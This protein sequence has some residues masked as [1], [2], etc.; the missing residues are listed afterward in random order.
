MNYFMRGFLAK[1]KVLKQD[2]EF[3]GVG[4]LYKNGGQFHLRTKKQG[5]G[6]FSVTL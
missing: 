3:S 5:Q 6:L 1:P 4:G 2:D